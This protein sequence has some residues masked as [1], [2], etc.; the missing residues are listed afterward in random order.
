MIL[1]FRE[2]PF[3]LRMYRCLY[4]RSNLSESELSYFWTLEKGYEGEQNFDALIQNLKG[5]YVL[6][7]DLLFEV[8]NTHFQIDS[9]LLSSE[10][11]YLFDVKNYE[12]D[13]IIDSDNKWYSIH[14][15]NSKKEIKNPLHQLD[16]CETLLKRLIQNLGYNTSIVPNLAFINPHFYLYQVPL[17]HPI[18]FFAQIERFM[19]QMNL[20]LKNSVIK[21]K[22]YQL[23]KKLVS[24]HIVE[25]PFIRKPEYSFEQLRKGIYCKCCHSFN[26]SSNPK[27]LVCCICGFKE[28]IETAV[29]RS[30]D[31][32]KVLFPNKKITTAVIHEWCKNLKSEKTIRRILSKNFKSMDTT[33]GNYYLINSD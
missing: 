1:K 26:I 10:Y 19:N 22:H 27:T 31:E 16:R 11:I 18:I 17:E 32:F 6:L 15:K 12:G 7:H 3:E 14:K 21:E 20:Q 30:I 4:I 25:S 29:L 24:H 13:Y 28:S 5:E 9:L 33:K 23:A 8:N 2:E